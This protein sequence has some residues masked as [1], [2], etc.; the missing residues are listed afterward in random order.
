MNLIIFLRGTRD[1]IEE[2]DDQESFFRWL[3]ENP[4]AGVLNEGAN[5]NNDEIDQDID[6]D[7]EGNI[8]VPEKSK[9]IDPLPPIDHSQIEYENFEKNFYEEHE[10]IKNLNDN[11]VN[12]L[13]KTLDIKVTGVESPKPICSFAHFGFD[14]QL[15]KAIRKSEFTQPTPI[16]AQVSL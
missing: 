3:E 14:E 1:D 5:N 7:E 9:F 16:Q 2:E 11:E 10:D 12:E 13:R 15:M 4:N 8:I 6:Y